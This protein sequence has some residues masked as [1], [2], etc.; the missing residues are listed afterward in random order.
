[1]D[2]KITTTNHLRKVK[3]KKKLHVWRLQ[4][5]TPKNTIDQIFNYKDLGKRN[6]INQFHKQMV[7]GDEKWVTYDN[8]VRKLSW[9]KCGEAAPTVAKPRQ[10]ARTDLLC[11]WW[12]WKGIIY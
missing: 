10:T 8:I 7:T 12:D 2:T 4:Q 11:V 3:F 9:S 6:E 5:L 1:M